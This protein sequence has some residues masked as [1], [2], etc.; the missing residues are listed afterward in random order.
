MGLIFEAE[1]SVLQGVRDGPGGKKMNQIE[2]SLILLAKS[3][4]AKCIAGS[5]G[6]PGR[7]KNELNRN[8]AI[9]WGR[10]EEQSVLQGVRD[11]PGGKKRN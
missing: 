10:A 2:I 5:E 3:R 1:Q 6:W 11:G 9:F 4:G 8:F 7:Q